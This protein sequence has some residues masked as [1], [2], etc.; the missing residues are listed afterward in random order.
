MEKLNRPE[1]SNKSSDIESRGSD[2]SSQEVAELVSEIF[3]LR[4]ELQRTQSELESA[5]ETIKRLTESSFQDQL[6]GLLNK[7]FFDN[8]AAENFN[9]EKD[10]EKIALVYG[11]INHFKHI[12]DTYG[13]DF[14]DECI[15]STADFLKK[16]FRE[17]DIVIRLHGDEFIVICRDRQ[18]VGYEGLQARLESMMGS[19][20]DENTRFNI[21]LGLAVFD[22]TER[23]GKIDTN[24]SDTQMRAEQE[25]YRV[26]KEMGGGR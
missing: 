22:N 3:R 1:S 7:N 14:G 13:H 23:D 2:E 17:E 11:D 18:G 26:K 12:N 21:A 6:T 9:A 16:N 25:M 5:Q 15:K 20:I 8:Y 4:F 10:R 24:L 19:S